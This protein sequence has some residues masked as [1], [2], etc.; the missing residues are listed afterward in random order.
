MTYSKSKSKDKYYGDKFKS[1]KFSPRGWPGL[2]GN[3]TAEEKQRKLMKCNILT[4]GLVELEWKFLSV[5]GFQFGFMYKYRLGEGACNECLIIPFPGVET[6]LINLQHRIDHIGIFG[7]LYTHEVYPE[8][9]VQ[10]DVKGYKR[11]TICPV[12]T[13][14]SPITCRYLGLFVWNNADSMKNPTLISQ[15]AS[16][17][18][19]GQRI[20]DFM[21][22]GAITNNELKSFE[23]TF[24]YTANATQTLAEGVPIFLSPYNTTSV[25]LE[26]IPGFDAT[27]FQPS[28]WADPIAYA[29]VKLKRDIKKCSMAPAFLGE[30][31]PRMSLTQK[32]QQL[33]A[34][35][36]AFRTHLAGTYD[37]IPTEAVS[38]ALTSYADFL[39]AVKTDS[40]GTSGISFRSAVGANFDFKSLSGVRQNEANM[41]GHH[42]APTVVFKGTEVQS[43][44]K[45]LHYTTPKVID[46]GNIS[47]VI[48]K[49]I[50]S[51]LVPDENIMQLIEQITQGIHTLRTAAGYSPGTGNM[52]GAL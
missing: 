11:K 20:N 50:A 22:V 14:P 43:G 16:V 46:T 9:I 19:E 5:G 52:D 32:V 8:K 25:I 37:G 4:S 15:F 48:S 35:V 24:M 42:A 12:L 7:G 13:W 21:R 40:G 31:D 27:K 18:G 17:F 45:S 38:S 30:S 1:D 29:M 6:F 36:E 33:G 23:D 2:P 39:G 26:S 49:I 47:E 41:M 3:A 44:S 10:I 28:R 51:S 34:H